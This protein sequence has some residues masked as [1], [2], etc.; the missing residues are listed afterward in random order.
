MGPAKYHKIQVEG[1]RAII[2][3]YM[4]YK[5]E[6]FTGKPSV[7]ILVQVTKPSKKSHHKKGDIT[8]WDVN[9]EELP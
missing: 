8:I 2:L 6:I 4:G 3:C 7:R 9:D 1:S 5:P